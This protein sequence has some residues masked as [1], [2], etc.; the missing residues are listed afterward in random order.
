MWMLRLS[1][2]YDDKIHDVIFVFDVDHL[3]NDEKCEDEQM[4]APRGLRRLKHEY[5]R[6]ESRWGPG[7]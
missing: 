6:F 2:S 5:R 7:C 3:H 1:L 4:S